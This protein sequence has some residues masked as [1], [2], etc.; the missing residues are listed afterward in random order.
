MLLGYEVVIDLETETAGAAQP[1]NLPQVH[2]AYLVDGHEVEAHLR[3]PTIN[4]HA[5]L[6]HHRGQRGNPGSMV[7]AA[8]E[9]PVSAEP[10]APRHVGTDFDPPAGGPLVTTPRCSPQISRAV[11]MGIRVDLVEKTL[12]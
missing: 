7:A 2:H 3:G 9:I 6:R 4:P 10:V 5:V 11:A 1:G 8:A 12:F